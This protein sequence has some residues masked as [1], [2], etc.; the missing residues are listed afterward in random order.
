MLMTPKYT[1]SVRR[2]QLLSCRCVCQG[3]LMTCPAGCRLIDCSWTP[4]RLRCCGV[5]HPGDR[6][7]Y[8]RHHSESAT[9]T[10]RHPHPC[11]TWVFTWTLT[12]VWGCKFHAP[13]DSVSVFWGSYALYDVLCHSQFSS[14]SL[15][16]W[17]W[18]SLTL[19]TP[20][21]PGSHRSSST[22]SRR[23][24]MQR[25]DLSFSQVVMITSPRCFIAC[26][27]SVHRNECHTS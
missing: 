8:L 27:G 13:S 17:Y 18:Q 25:L 9:T 20:R 12:S 15:W 7:S 22:V 6:V 3:V 16:R 24:W 2:R 1:A 4:A 19:K 10:C 14:L 23:S 5:H 11:E 21:W 26:I